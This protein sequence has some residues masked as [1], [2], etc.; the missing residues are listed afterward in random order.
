[1][2]YKIFDWF[3]ATIFGLAIGYFMV[4]AFFANS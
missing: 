3:L 1:M 2:I 4:I